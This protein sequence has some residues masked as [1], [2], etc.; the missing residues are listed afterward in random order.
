MMK[1]QRQ[2]GGESPAGTSPHVSAERS[3]TGRVV[4][5]LA[6]T[7]GA[8]LLEFAMVLPFL[9]VF[10]VG[11]IQFG[12]AFTLKQKM[13]NAAREGARIMVSNILAGNGCSGTNCSAQAAASAV[14][15]YMTNAGVDSSCLNSAA[16]TSVGT[17]AWKFTCN[18]ITL[19]INHQYVYTGGGSPVTGTQV[20]LTYP[21]KWF[22]NDVIR[23]L[24]PNSNLGLPSTLTESAVM[25]NIA[26][27]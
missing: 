2:T 17:E 10:A 27:N 16:A 23:L 11:I 4:S 14:A 13:A 15:N 12:G 19:T 25:E 3:V 20:T 5:L 1:I 9:L 24:A 8:Q 21:Y 7:E 18:G 6:G 22:F 26:N